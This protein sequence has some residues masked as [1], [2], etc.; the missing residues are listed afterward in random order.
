MKKYADR[1]FPISENTWKG[2]VDD[3]EDP[4]TF[5]WHQRV[6]RL[7]LQNIPDKIKTNRLQKFCILGFA[8]DTGV[9]RNNG[10][11][12]AAEGPVFIRKELSN[13]PDIFGKRA[14]LYDAG[15]IH[16][17]DGNLEASQEALGR[18]VSI[19]LKQNIRPIVLGGGHETAFGH[20]SGIEQFLSE[21]GD[22]PAGIINF[23]A[24]FD[25]RP[26]DNGTSSGTMFRQIAD[27]CE[28]KGQAF[29]Y[30][31]AGIQEQGNTLSLFR[32][33]KDLKVEYIPARHM[34]EKNFLRITEQLDTFLQKHEHIYLTVCT[35]VFSAAFAPGV[36]APQSLGLP[37]GITL[38]L[39]RYIAKSQKVIG[40]DV[41][42][43]SPRL[44]EG[45]RT[46][47]LAASVVFAYVH[48]LLYPNGN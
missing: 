38:E 19:L 20:Y 31:V 22:Q 30:F 21:T 17:K 36:S 42:E 40:F 16:C 6:E 12:G 41:A 7:D 35:D 25:L 9:E 26:Y 45:N 1:Y 29:S 46:A 15:D 23:D 11:I 27:L 2:R 4:D 5:R 24:H 28:T 10:R 48:A 13:L 37:P 44:D 47:K 14:M 18:A 3:P 8:C 39:I 34:N 33:A 43:V 32:K